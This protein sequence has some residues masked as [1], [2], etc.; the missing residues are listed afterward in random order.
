METSPTEAFKR[1]Y[2]DAENI[3]LSKTLNTKT[4]EELVTENLAFV[5]HLINKEFSRYYKHVGI[6]REVLESAGIHGLTVAAN[7]SKYGTFIR[8]ASF[9]IRYYIYSEIR[10][11]F[12]IKRQSA[13][14]HKLNKLRK[15]QARFVQ[16][17]GRQP[18]Y[19]ELAAL[20]GYSEDVVKDTIDFD[21]QNNT[22]TIS[23]D[24]MMSDPEFSEEYDAILEE[25]KGMDEIDVTGMENSALKDL[26]SR[27]LEGRD[28]EIML[29]H[30]FEH[31]SL[32]DIARDYGKKH[33]IRISVAIE[34]SI[35]KIKSH[36]AKEHKYFNITGDSPINSPFNKRMHH[37]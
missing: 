6:P 17:H 16:K 4:P 10:G 11:Y 2:T 33:T 32:Q 29:K 35:R 25:D 22:G 19:S 14:C 5:H 7:K 24:A 34:R 21:D 3:A 8:Y 26:V 27:V 28:R 31:K 36:V 15:E 23:L 20:T 13:Y 12:F 37:V 1:K 9:W 30:Y 18:Y